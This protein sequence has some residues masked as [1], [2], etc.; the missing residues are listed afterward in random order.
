MP[1]SLYLYLIEAAFVLPLVGAILALVLY[2]V[3]GANTAT[4]FL[5]AASGVV[6]TI[7]IAGYF[8][9]G[10][11]NVAI[12]V[13]SGFTVTPLAAFF[14]ALVYLGTFLTSI[15]AIQGLRH[16]K[17][18]YSIPWLNVTSALFILGMQATIMSGSVVAFLIAWEV[19]SIAAYFL[20]IA[21][22]TDDSLR[23]G[24]LYFL[25]T[26][27]GF[28]CLASGFL[29]LA[30]GNVFATWSDV[31]LGAFLISPQ[32][33]SVAFLLLLAGFGS[34]AGL[35]PLHQWLPYAHPQAPSHSSALLS[36]T[37]L[38]VALFGFIQSLFLFPFIPMWWALVVI[39]VGLGSGFFGALHA[40]V[41]RDAKRLLAW[42]SVENMG[43]I[44]SGVG[45]VL[46]LRTL[47]DS[48]VAWS[49]AGTMSI[50]VVLHTVNHFFFKTGLFLA[51]GA[52]ASATHTRDLDLLGGLARAW[53]L[54]SGV[55]LTLALAAAALPPLGTFFGEWMYL[56]SLAVAMS[57]LPTSF[58]VASALIMVV[59]AL[60]GGLAIF[61]FV[62]LFALVF[63]GRA[64]SDHAEVTTRMF[65]T[66][67][68]SPLLCVVGSLLVA[69]SAGSV[70]SDVAMQDAI[71]RVASLSVMPGASIN[72]WFVFALFALVIIGV[73]LIRRAFTNVAPVRITDTWDCGTP[74]TPRMQYTATGFAAPI[75]FFFR[76]V[77]VSRKDL[78]KEPIAAGNPWIAR[79][80]LD[81]TIGS[82]WEHT[83]YM[84]IAY[85]VM[86][87]STWTKRL[88]SGVIQLYLLFVVCALAVVMII[89]L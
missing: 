79:R 69:V 11:G 88:Q 67:L 59:L 57:V 85:W 63:L 49:L 22:R 41:E 26:H 13:I 70:F 47:P 78:I 71:G 21:D 52:V 39:V 68:W 6:G 29:L 23:A 37:M 42:S 24:F 86:R 14:L 17:K 31:A 33:L 74:L 77:L 89:A 62:K 9:S 53:P 45:I 43:L 54:F 75:R 87:A 56:Q 20:V 2:R 76:S 55:F 66:L 30:Q 61:T 38:K 27:I 10:Q 15:Y 83:L 16:Y 8:V 3:H 5:F 4:Q 84:P 72:V 18:I 32:M 36:G 28:V 65:G 19:M 81:S 46:V 34:K 64:R 25:M 35:V 40:A 12:Q 48:P 50:F 80:R 44:F 73:Y 60:I 7:G 82:L 58:A 51:V 1:T